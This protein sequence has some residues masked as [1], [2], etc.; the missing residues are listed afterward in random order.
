MMSTDP[1]FTSR[2]AVEIDGFAHRNPIPAASRLGPLLISS[3]VVGYDP[4]TSVVPQDPAAQARNVF[5]HAA[6]I[7]AAAGA[8][9]DDV[10]R[11]TFYV[12][13]LALRPVV[14]APW[15]EI[16]PDATTRPARVTHASDSDLGIRAEFIVFVQARSGA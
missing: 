9:W 5:D 14:N 1:R 11:M 10:V 4:G 6:A 2:R 7:L 13:D 15:L 8:T 3:M 12:P 16:F